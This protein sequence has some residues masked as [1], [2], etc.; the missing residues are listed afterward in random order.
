ML[1]TL[2]N[3]RVPF[4][5]LK[6]KKSN[7]STVFKELGVLALTRAVSNAGK[8]PRRQLSDVV[9]LYGFCF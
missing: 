9:A 1:T 4:F 6:K 3:V 5:P 2:F 7:F 8:P